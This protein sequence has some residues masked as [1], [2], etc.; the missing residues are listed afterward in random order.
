MFSKNDPLCMHSIN[1]W[2]LNELTNVG[3]LIFRPSV[4][5]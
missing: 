5:F 1:V 2:A 3:V 4:R